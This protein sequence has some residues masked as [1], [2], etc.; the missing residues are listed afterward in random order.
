M[1]EKL[2]QVTNKVFY[3]ILLS[4]GTN[5]K[6]LLKELSRVAK[7]NPSRYHFCVYYKGNLVSI[8]SGFLKV[9]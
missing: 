3:Y 9:E 7:F 5:T 1:N 6:L 2:I 8:S 4:T